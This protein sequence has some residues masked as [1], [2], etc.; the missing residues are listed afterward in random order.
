MKLLVKALVAMAALCLVGCTAMTTSI[1]HKDLVAQTKMSDTIFLQP[2][3]KDQQTVYVQVRNTS[4]QPGFDVTSKIER[5]ITARGYVVTDDLDEAHYMLQANVLKVTSMTP[6]QLQD[7]QESTANSALSGAAV[8]AGVGALTGDST[9]TLAAGLV[10]AAVG[11][12]ADASVKAVT[13]VAVVD[14][15]VSERVAEGEA[16]SQ[17]TTSDLQNGSSKT[18]QNSSRDAQWQR[19]QT[20]LTA[21]ADKVNLKYEQAEPVLEENV[22]N[23]IGGIF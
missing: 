2:V 7:V 4:D 16:V 22:A 20:R 11:T 10:G 9:T 17:Q 5:A 15:Q 1:S 3:P 8:G 23:A 13:Y 18:V 14:L 21:S 19:Y 6:E 12:I